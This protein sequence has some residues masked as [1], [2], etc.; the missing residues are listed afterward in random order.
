MISGD[1]ARHDGVAGADTLCLGH[2]LDESH[3]ARVREA[4]VAA[5]Q[6]GRLSEERLAEAAARVAASHA[7]VS[8]AARTASPGE[9]GLAAARRALRSR[10][11]VRGSGPLVVGRGRRASVA[12][13]PPSMMFGG[14]IR[15]L[16]ADAKRFELGP[17]IPPRSRRGAKHIPIVV[18]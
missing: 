1:S 5:V 6:S 16:G 7:P 9:V 2:D 3:V 14:I 11:D 18:R 15:E 13:G 4:I 17:S 12:A 10:P 8:A